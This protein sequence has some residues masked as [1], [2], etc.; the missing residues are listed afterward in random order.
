MVMFII[1]RFAV[2]FQIA[3]PCFF[4]LRYV[5]INAVIS[6]SES[7]VMAFAKKNVYQPMFGL[8]TESRAASQYCEVRNS[9]PTYK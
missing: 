7:T 6:E 9:N 4:A 8:P 5:R 3:A 2:L 1:N